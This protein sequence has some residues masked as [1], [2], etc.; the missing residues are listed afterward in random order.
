M[1]VSHYIAEE[2][3]DDINNKEKLSKK[4]KKFSDRYKKDNEFQ[5]I[6]SDFKKYL[7]SGDEKMLTDIKKRLEELR[8]VRKLEGSGEATLPFKDRRHMGDSQHMR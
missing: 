1:L 7:E 5:L 3:L 2:L 8:N 4:F 6:Y